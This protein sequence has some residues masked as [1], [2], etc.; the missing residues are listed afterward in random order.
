MHKNNKYNLSLSTSH[1]SP[2]IFHCSPDNLFVFLV[3]PIHSLPSPWKAHS[4]LFWLCLA[5]FQGIEGILF[6][7]FAII[8]PCSIIW[9]C[10]PFKTYQKCHL[11]VTLAWVPRGYKQVLL[12]YPHGIVKMRLQWYRS[13][14]LGLIH[15]LLICLFLL[16][17][18]VALGPCVDY[19]YNPDG[20]LEFLSSSEIW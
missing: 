19:V 7:V 13:D 12:W 17:S 20:K 14:Y 6:W 16:P 15:C 10:S 8:W 1:L 3:S 9:S 2:T 5:S 18:H 4:L 11:P